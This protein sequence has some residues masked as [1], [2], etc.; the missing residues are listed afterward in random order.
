MVGL[1]YFDSWVREA[2]G[3]QQRLLILEL[4]GTG[5]ITALPFPVCCTLGGHPLI[6]S[7][8]YHSSPAAAWHRLI[9]TSLKSTL[10]DYTRGSRTGVIKAVLWLLFPCGRHA[11]AGAGVK[12]A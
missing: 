9:Y 10:H 3:C 5:L 2:A 1:L 8:T 7:R 11:Y 6:T 12:A 4:M